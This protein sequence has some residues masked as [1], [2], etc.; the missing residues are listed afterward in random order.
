MTGFQV[1]RCE[2]GHAQGDHLSGGRSLYAASQGGQ[3]R[4]PDC[5][6]PAFTQRNEAEWLEQTAQRL[7]EHEAAAW[8]RM[9]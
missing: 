6:C 5:D 4:A 2:C 9:G 8:R 7:D 3:C 1:P